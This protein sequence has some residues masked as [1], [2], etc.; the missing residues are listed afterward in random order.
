MKT[1]PS[2]LTGIA[3][4]GVS[5]LI[6]LGACSRDNNASNTASTPAAS[7]EQSLA[8]ATGVTTESW[9]DLQDYAYEQR[10]EFAAQVNAYAAMLD[11][12]IRAAGDNASDELAEARDELRATAN[13]VSNATSETWNDTKE[14]VARAW[15][16]AQSAYSAAE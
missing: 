13:E 10:S 9:A 3:A 12:R 1:N 5:A 11:Q 16:K 2:R 8:A 4:F 14:R 7:A 15:E 6:F